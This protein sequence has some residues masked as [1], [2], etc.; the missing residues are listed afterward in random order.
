MSL[1]YC[2]DFP[3]YHHKQC[4][5]RPRSTRRCCAGSGLWKSQIS[6]LHHIE[7]QNPNLKPFHMWLIGLIVEFPH[8]ISTEVR[9][10]RG[11]MRRVTSRAFC[12]IKVC[13]LALIGDENHY[14]I[15]YCCKWNENSKDKMTAG[16]YGCTSWLLFTLHRGIRYGDRLYIFVWH[17]AD[18]VI[19]TDCVGACRPSL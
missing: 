17:P 3:L 2:G 19:H 12:G 18:D 1:W 13:L 9:Q 14:R 5:A 10:N 8:H 11:L 15:L 7:V 16:R 6:R 4:Q